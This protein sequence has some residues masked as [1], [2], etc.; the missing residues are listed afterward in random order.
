MAVASA[1]ACA[2]PRVDT[3]RMP[4]APHPPLTPVPPQLKQ[5]LQGT[6]GRGV[7]AAAPAAARGLPPP[8]Q[9]PFAEFAQG[10]RVVHD[11]RGAGTVMELMEDGRRRVMFDDGD[12]HR[13]QPSSMHKLRAYEHG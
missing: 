5:E 3:P 10:A 2:R 8:A 4:S 9:W 13:Y 1:T 7:G 11:S 12:E 6:A